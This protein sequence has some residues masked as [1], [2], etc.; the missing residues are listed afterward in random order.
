MYTLNAIIAVLLG[1]AFTMLGIGKLADVKQM[2]QARVHL[3]LPAGL[4]R[5]IG[6]LEVLGGVGVLVGLHE[7]LPLVGVMAAVGLVG[8]TIGAAAYHQK[9]GDA[10]KQWLPAVAMGSMAIFYIILRIATA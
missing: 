6:V 3:G 1:V 5:V 7:D 4:F 9:A 8:M 2:A 10:M